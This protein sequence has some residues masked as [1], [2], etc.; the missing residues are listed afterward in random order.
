M[1]K[2]TFLKTTF[3]KRKIIQNFAR[4]FE[5][6]VFVL[7][8]SFFVV[9]NNIFHAVVNDKRPFPFHKQI[10]YVSCSKN[11][12][13]GEVLSHALFHPPLLEVNNI[14]CILSLFLHVNFI[15]KTIVSFSTFLSY[16]TCR[17]LT[18]LSNKF[19]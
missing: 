14:Y 13:F 6:Q 15:D 17:H 19:N 18:F 16:K 10:R 3:L 1:A 11:E 8:N 9:K 5:W 4:Y 2:L 12:Y 7:K